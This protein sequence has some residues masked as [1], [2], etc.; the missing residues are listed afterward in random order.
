[1]AFLSEAD[2]ENTIFE[3]LQVELQ[4]EPLY[5]EEVLALKVRDAIRECKRRRC[6]QFTKM[7]EEQIV[8]DL[9]YHYSVIKQ[10][11]LIYYNR[12]GA[13]G[14]TVHYENTVHRSFFSDDDIFTDVIPFVKVL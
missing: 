7:T 5:N 9:E 12:M 8:Q 3:E 11:A 10:A 6:Y 13:E 14:E 2:L 1:M 4:D